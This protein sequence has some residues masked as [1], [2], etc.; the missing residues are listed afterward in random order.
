MNKPTDH[1]DLKAKFHKAIDPCIMGD[2]SKY[3]INK[4][5]KSM[6]GEDYIKPTSLGEIMHD[7]VE[8]EGN[9]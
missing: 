8:L 2:N 1:S 9:Y 4:A 3:F 5:Y 6:F 7:I